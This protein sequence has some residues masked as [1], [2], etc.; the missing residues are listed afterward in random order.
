MAI[1]QFNLFAGL[2][3]LI[4]L[5]AQAN[6]C[7]FCSSVA[8]PLSEEMDQADV[9]GFA[10][11]VKGSETDSDAVFKFEQLLKGEK[12][13]Q[14][15]SEM[16]VPYFGSA[17]PGQKF[18]L[19][20]IDPP[21]MLWSFPRPVTPEGAKYLT[22]IVKL[23]KDPVKRL[24]FYLQ[25]LENS[26]PMIAGDAY[27]EFAPAPYEEIKLLKDEMDRK[28]LIE[29]VKDTD[30]SADRRRLYF[31]M[32]GIVGNPKD[33]KL[34]EGMMRSEDP[35]QRAGLDAM[36]ACYITLLGDKALDTIDEL[37]L[38]DLQR[39]Y[40]DTYA[41]LQAIRFHGSE[42][43]VVDRKRLIE[44]LRLILDRREYAD[45]VIPDL[46]RW[47]D[48]SQMDRLVT[49]FKD[50]DEETSWVRVPVINYLRA[51]PLPK[52]KELLDELK[53]IDPAAFKRAVSYFPVQRSGADLS[54]PNS[55]I[56]AR[57][58]P[59]DFRG[60]VHTDALSPRLGLSSGDSYAAAN[61]VSPG[62]AS[63]PSVSASLLPGSAS[64]PPVAVVPNRF[65]LM[66]VVT[67]TSATLWIAMWLLLSG[68]G[69]PLALALLREQS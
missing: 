18:L 38:K 45:L 47:E 37:F 55:R 39:E 40:G 33:A 14:A 34:L 41:A 21:D 51:C 66:S 56:I 23:P 11:I 3:L 28:Q 22:A 9:V 64:L 26:D 48:W 17:K 54:D 69:N 46:A 50:A 60:A 19:L 36:I 6:H 57:S 30:M 49:L 68:A 1:R 43:G 15:G 61:V 65:F 32:L 58:A 5:P 4:A 25:H 29:W 24:R 53:E 10:T 16:T 31:V 7:P 8:Q 44:S 12:L 42:G 59:A 62:L 20:G 63:G 67:I 52:A 2:L 27:D 35:L 13:L